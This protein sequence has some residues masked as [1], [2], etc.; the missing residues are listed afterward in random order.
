MDVGSQD[1]KPHEKVRCYRNSPGLNAR[2]EKLNLGIQDT[3][4]ICSS[5]GS[6]LLMFCVPPFAVFTQFMSMSRKFV[7]FLCCAKSSYT[8]FTQRLHNVLGLRCVRTQRNF[9]HTPAHVARIKPDTTQVNKCGR[10]ALTRPYQT[11][12][13][14]GRRSLPSSKSNAW[15]GAPGGPNRGC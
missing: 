14:G 10:R 1:P 11:R 12:H 15:Y 3:H 9:G 6:D 4:V 7:V 13:D 2:V 8:T 5:L